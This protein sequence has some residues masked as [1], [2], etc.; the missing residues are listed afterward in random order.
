MRTDTREARRPL[1]DRTFFAGDEEDYRRLVR[2]FLAR[3]VNENLDKY[4]SGELSIKELHRRAAD[5]G[6]IATGVPTA[7]GGLGQGPLMNFIL[8]HELSR[9]AGFG[10]LGPVLTTDNAT[11]LIFNVASDR[12][13]E[14]IAP[15]ILEGAIQAMGLTEPDAGTNSRGIRT[16]AR[17]DGDEWVIKGNKIFISAG[18]YADICYVIAKTNPADEEPALSAFYVPAGT[19]GFTQSR[20]DMMGLPGRGLGEWSFTDVR[21]PAWHLIG[22]EG[23]ALKL[24]SMT[25]A[26][27]RVHCAGRAL[28][29]AEL[30][31]Q[32][33]IDYTK[34]RIVAGGQPLFELQNTR[35][36]LAEMYAQLEAV[37]ALVKQMVDRVRTDTSTPFD[38]A[39]CKTFAQDTSARI[40]DGC[41]QLW[42]AQGL[43]EEQTISHL[44]TSNRSM[45]IL[46]GTS[47][48]LKLSVASRL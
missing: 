13:K 42:G 43:A 33:T 36:Q 18:N 25:M 2:D 10:L 21:V 37:N 35:M 24:F 22:N 31:L 5:V 15:L 39:A 48:L 4:V 30:A 38:A 26:N 17:R 3:E 41:L 32:L 19:P 6:V 1:H 11:Q 14:A 9:T 12:I 27:D 40:L 23:E 34:D 8:S 45:R 28:G 47:E 7:Y 29:Q 16:T 20:V 44:Y 46:A